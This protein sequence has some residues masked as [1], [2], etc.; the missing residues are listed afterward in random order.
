MPRPPLVIGTW[1][2]INRRQVAPKQWVASARYRDHDGVTRKVERTAAT[3]QKAE[4]ALKD[5]LTKRLTLTEEDLT[6]ESTVRAVGEVWLR[7][8]IEGVKALNTERRYREVFEGVVTQGLG[9][10]R[11]REISVARLDRF[12]KLTASTRGSATAIVT[13]TVLSGIIGLAARHGAID[14]NPLRDVA[15]IKKTRKE[16]RVLPIEQLWDLRSKMYANELAVL[17]DVPEPVDFMLGSGARIGETLALRW[18]DLDLEHD[19]A[20]AQIRAT[21]VWVNGRGMIIQ[22]H[23]KTSSS[24]RRL[25]LPPF[26]TE[27]LER[28]RLRESTNDFDLVFASA[29]GSV[30]APA[31]LRRQWRDL[32]EEIGYDW[33]VPHT[34]R[35]SVATLAEDPELASQQLGHSGTA[36]TKLHYI[37]QVHEGPDLTEILQGIADPALTRRKQSETTSKDDRRRA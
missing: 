32:R 2:R 4:D 6:Q 17:R 25:K 18:A 30:R 11:M 23:P 36:T 5:Y 28:R 21:V 13:K 31:N 26:V 1:G 37:P 34:F 15:T 14:R 9:G 33:V 27:M 3:G 29:V 19:V 12:L 8:E 35:K 10:V 22:E 16:V 24:R 20:T 7:D